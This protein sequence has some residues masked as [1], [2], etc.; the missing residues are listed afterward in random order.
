MSLLSF[1]PITPSKRHQRRVVLSAP[2]NS[3]QYKLAKFKNKQR[4]D[5]VGHNL[6]HGVKYNRKVLLH[7]FFV[8]QPNLYSYIIT[9]FGFMNSPLKE[10]S[11][12]KTIYNL[13]KLTKK[14]PCF[15]PGF[16]LQHFNTFSS[17]QQLVSQTVPLYLAPLNL[18][19]SFIF[20]NLNKKPTFATSSGVFASKRKLDKKTKLFII[21]LP[22]LKQQY[23]PQSTLCTLAST[24]NLLVN[25]QVEGK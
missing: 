19:I 12:I 8:T 2:Y 20:N 7:K 22:S 11:Y 4:K 23:L 10:F 14:T 16:I 5:L 3:L 25:K 1:F 17:V 24:I 18:S 21:I 9:G 13:N 15:Y 6:I